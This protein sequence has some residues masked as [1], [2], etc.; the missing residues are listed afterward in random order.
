M[1]DYFFELCN[2]DYQLTEYVYYTFS[3]YIY[4]C[5]C[6]FVDL[7][8]LLKK[9]YYFTTDHIVKLS[10]LDGLIEYFRLRP[11]ENLLQFWSLQLS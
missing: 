1:K 6:I 5:V 10:L 11:K 7:V 9:I 3:V 4:I 8:V 2:I